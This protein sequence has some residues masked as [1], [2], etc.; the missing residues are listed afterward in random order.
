MQ[1]KIF[2]IRLD[3][4]KMDIDQEKINTFMQSV[5]VK[6]ISNQFV[7]ATPVNYWSIL[8]YYIELSVRNNLPDKST[9]YDESELDEQEKLIYEALKQWRIDKSSE[10]KIPPFLIC[11][12]TELMTISKIKPEKPE[13]FF[14]I[15]GFAEIKIA[16][17][18]EE[19]IV[20]L[21]SL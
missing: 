13:D 17:F 4:E 21:N 15:K 16:R 10:L 20:V 18:A 11:H 1:L 9:V 19:I 2:H 7:S 5:N 6:K 14:Q 8:V 3:K 12:N